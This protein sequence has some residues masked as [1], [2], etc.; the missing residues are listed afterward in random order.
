MILNRKMPYFLLLITRFPTHFRVAMD[1]ITYDDVSEVNQPEPIA[2]KISFK[3]TSLLPSFPCACFTETLL[4]TLA[5]TLPTRLPLST[6][7]PT[8]L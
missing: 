7:F 3:M 1:W 5:A 4:T 8:H 6:F 2:S